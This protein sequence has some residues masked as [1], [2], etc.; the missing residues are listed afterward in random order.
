MPPP[1]PAVWFPQTFEQRANEVLHREL[2]MLNQDLAGQWSTMHGGASSSA[3]GRPPGGGSGRATRANRGIREHAEQGYHVH[4]YYR[5]GDSPARSAR[6]P[7]RTAAAGP[8]HI[9][10]LVAQALRQQYADARFAVESGWV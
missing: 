9:S 6:P 1:S 10:P 8:G 3:N 7:F 4:G 5:G 2:I